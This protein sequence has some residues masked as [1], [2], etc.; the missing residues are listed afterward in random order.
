M[1]V[2]ARLSFLLLPSPPRDQ[3]EASEKAGLVPGTESLGAWEGLRR[4]PRVSP[5]W[6]LG[7][8]PWG[9]W[10]TLPAPG[11]THG[12]AGGGW[13]GAG[14][15]SSKGLPT[16]L[17]SRG[18]HSALQGGRGPSWGVCKHTRAA[19]LGT[20]PWRLLQGV[21]AGKGG[22]LEYHVFPGAAV[23]GLSQPRVW[24]PRMPV[25]RSL[26]DCTGAEVL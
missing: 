13:V 1:Q 4:P 14:R 11:R 15:S 9:R 26:L 10:L 19:L 5:G 8:G 2:S 16:V 20:H 7:S 18:N 22:Q 17:A 21:S 24:L 12:A 3:G 6:P 25:L 23:C